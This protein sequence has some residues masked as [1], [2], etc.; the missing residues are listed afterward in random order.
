MNSNKT[1]SI[2]NEGFF[3]RLNITTEQLTDICYPT[4]SDWIEDIEIMESIDKIENKGLEL[5]TIVRI[6]QTPS[7]ASYS[8]TPKSIS[9]TLRDILKAIEKI[10]T[11]E[12]NIKKHLES[13]IFN[14]YDFRYFGLDSEINDCI[15]QVA[16]FGRVFY[17]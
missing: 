17:G 4:D 10:V 6:E 12:T 3:K 14:S 7:S 1:Y 5:D 11:G 9:I 15:L 16:F 2:C 13:R 8:F